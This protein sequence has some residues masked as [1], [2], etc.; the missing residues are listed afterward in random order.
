M[1]RSRRSRSHDV[2]CLCASLAQEIHDRVAKQRRGP[3]EEG[4]TSAGRYDK[5][6]FALGPLQELARRTRHS[7]ASESRTASRPN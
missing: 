7:T 4:A 1:I 3:V 2:L 5:G 6:A